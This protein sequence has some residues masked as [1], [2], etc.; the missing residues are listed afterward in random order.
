MLPIG[1]A[2]NPIMVVSSPERG[3]LRFAMGFIF[4]LSHGWSRVSC[5]GPIASSLDLCSSGKLAYTLFR[6]LIRVHEIRHDVANGTR[7][8]GRLKFTESQRRQEPAGLNRR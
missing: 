1:A 8:D 5:D 7:C 4:A 2:P 3:H 6:V